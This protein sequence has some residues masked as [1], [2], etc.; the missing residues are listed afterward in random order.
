MNEDAD[1]A[2]CTDVYVCQGG[3]GGGE[4]EAIYSLTSTSNMQKEDEIHRGGTQYSNVPADTV[5]V[6][7]TRISIN[8]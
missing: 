3:R 2:H 8:E 7:R 5:T 1:L 6:C 4:W